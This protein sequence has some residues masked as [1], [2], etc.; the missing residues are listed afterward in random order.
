MTAETLK[1]TQIRGMKSEEGISFL[2]RLGRACILI[3]SGIGPLEDITK[4]E[5]LDIYRSLGVYFDALL[6][7]HTHHDHARAALWLA[8]EFKIPVYTTKIGKKILAN[9]ARRDGS[10]LEA[11]KIV[12][13]KEGDTIK[14]GNAKINV[15]K[16][17]HSTPETVGFDIHIGDK[18][19]V[20]LGDGKHTGM[21][22]ESYKKSIAM[23]NKMAERPILLLTMDALGVARP[24]LTSPE[25][26]VANA[27]ASTVLNGPDKKHFIFLS[28]SN[29]N[30]LQEI[31]RRILEKIYID[32]KRGGLS[33][34]GISFLFRGAAIQ[35]AI[36]IIAEEADLPGLKKQLANKKAKTTVIFGTT[37]GE[38]SYDKRLWE[39][40]KQNRGRD[41][42]LVIRPGDNIIYSS[43]FIP[44]RNPKINKKNI[45]EMRQ[46]IKCLFEYGAN[47]FVNR[48][49]DKLLKIE[50]YATA[51]I[52]AVGGHE[53]QEG[54]AR[55]IEILSP[56]LI[57]P[58]H[59]LEGDYSV[60]QKLAGNNTIVLRPNNFE[61]INLGTITYG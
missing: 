59:L 60:L 51:G 47:I 41:D 25:F 48:G 26:P 29:I 12:I 17:E 8:E 15:V 30:R 19:L 49:M 1:I 58:F 55:T 2:Y 4:S 42:L 34:N 28:G 31:I 11:I 16:L 44:H 37:G 40:T 13:I 23:M 22:S 43:G 10:N 32:N 50:P 38:Y 53:K 52:Y 45:Y 57:M 24:G 35:E 27:I 14:I 9:M 21:R 54:I 46:F 33:E 39:F 56:Q 20:H 3:D 18:H 7:T 36:D 6:L 61:E 5:I